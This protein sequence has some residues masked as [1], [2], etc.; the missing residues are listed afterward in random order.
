MKKPPQIPNQKKFS[1]PQ[2][3]PEPEFR[4]SLLD[5]MI[6]GREYESLLK[7]KTN[8]KIELG[9]ELRKSLAEIEAIRKKPA[10]VYCA[11]VVNQLKSPTGIDYKDDLPFSEMVKTIPDEIEEIDVILVTP[12]GIGQQVSSFVDKLRPRFKKVSFLLPGMAMSA[13]TI[14]A[15]SGDEIIMTADGRIGPIDPQVLNK[16]GRLV[17]AQ[18]I[19]TAVEWI[20]ER[21]E[22]ALK[23]GKQPNW[24]DVLILKQ[25]DPRDLGTA[26][27]SSKYSVDL[28]ENYL[29]N[30]KFK[31]WINHKSDGRPVT[32]EERKSR[33]NKIATDLCD[34]SKW[35][36]HSTGITREIAWDVCNLEIIRSE[37]IE[38]LDRALKRFWA[39][40]YFLFDNHSFVK[41]FCSP[42]YSLIRQEKQN[43]L[44]PQKA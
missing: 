44:Q 37:S 43:P 8:Y 35:K 32:A 23:I 17:P 1:G 25:I 26:L 7:H 28:V 10:I 11:N 6:D 31:N 9:T 15:M 30:Y 13:G 22:A 33:A 34:H 19:L 5:D 16:E 14:F 3:P 20:R 18:S 40:C 39:M 2:K 36:T 41:I 12:G 42:F 27:S 24:T 4:S 38:G 21:G 29:N